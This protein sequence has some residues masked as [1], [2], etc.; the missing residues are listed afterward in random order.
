MSRARDAG[1]EW[2]NTTFAPKKLNPLACFT[3]VSLETLTK[4]RSKLIG[5]PRMLS[6]MWGV[7]NMRMS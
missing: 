2:V 3:S 1:S 4:Q 5:N 6:D 7:H